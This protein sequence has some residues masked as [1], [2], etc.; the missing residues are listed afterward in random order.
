MS[1]DG[2]AI[3][4][5]RWAMVGAGLTL[6]V[7]SL[8][9]LG[10]YWLWQNGYLIAWAIAACIS[11]VAAWAAQRWLLAPIRGVPT[12]V[13]T[14]PAANV[15]GDTTWTPAELAAWAKVQDIVTST[16]PA[17][18]GSREALLELGQRTVATVAS[19]LHPER[20]EPLLQF[21]APE[22]L[23]LIERV[24][25]RLDTF[26]RES[27]PMG[28]RLTLAQLKA[29]YEWRGAIEMAE[30]A[31]SVWRVLRMMNPASALANEVRERV[32]KELVAWG[33]SHVAR[34]LATHY[35]EEVG[36]AA[37]DLYGG[38]LRIAPERMAGHV[39]D[40]SARDLAAVE[41]ASAEPLRLL[42]AG[43]VSAGKSSLVNALGEEVR[44]AVDALP[45]TARFTPYR[46]MREGL[47]AALVI[48]SPGLAP[49]EDHV[50][51][52]ISEVER[53]DLLLW[54]CPA[55]RADREIDRAALT[56]LRAHFAART[57]RIP[58]PVLLVLTHVDL[59]RP[60]QEWTPPYNLNDAASAKATSMRAA[61]EAAAGD[62]GFKTDDVI[63]CALGASRARYN[64]DAIWG[65]IASSLPDA[66]RTKLVR[67][68]RDA[69]GAWD[70]R[71][72]MSQAQGA[73]RVLVKAIGR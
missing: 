20:K 66:Q 1:R 53:T 27:V 58:P 70:W 44:A 34:K 62:L 18:L 28:D 67:T 63:P 29:L 52:L 50:S 8:V 64:V 4:A 19:S 37:I 35:V 43:Q 48:D 42:V 31:W 45:A 65:A 73:G 72:V 49:G 60:F 56:A 6:P 41:N 11:T 71:R 12:V 13:A 54:V 5:L 22:A 59:L 47:P 51:A 26:V 2:P 7:L 15:P 36:R 69:E 3:R 61:V 30:Q 17:Q 14:D 46:L 38:R 21:T 32:S 16:D 55:N 24:A 68:L 25:G 33:K 10:S 9:P 23:A 57:N 39:T 40:A